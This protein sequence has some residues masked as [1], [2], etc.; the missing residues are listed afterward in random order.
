MAVNNIAYLVS[1]LYRPEIDNILIVLCQGW[2][3]NSFCVQLTTYQWWLERV[4]VKMNTIG[5]SCLGRNLYFKTLSHLASGHFMAIRTV[6]GVAQL[7]PQI[8]SFLVFWV[9]LKIAVYAIVYA[10]FG[11]HTVGC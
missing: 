4:I 3:Y 5:P 10:M 6:T 2:S 7:L 11:T 9:S 1:A 8:L